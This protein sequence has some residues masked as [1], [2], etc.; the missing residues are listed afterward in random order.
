M[1][2]HGHF[3]CQAVVKN[4]V[5]EVELPYNHGNDLNVVVP[6]EVINAMNDVIVNGIVI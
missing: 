6:Y 3:P 1:R 2:M 5:Y 4:T